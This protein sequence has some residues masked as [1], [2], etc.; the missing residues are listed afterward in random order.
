MNL[1]KLLLNHCIAF[2]L[3]G[4]CLISCSEP[5]AVDLIIENHLTS[6]GFNGDLSSKAYCLDGN[7]EIARYGINVPFSISTDGKSYYVF[8]QSELESDYIGD[9]LPSFSKL[10][11]D[12]KAFLVTNFSL[13]PEQLSNLDLEDDLKDDKIV[14]WEQFPKSVYDNWKSTEITIAN[15]VVLLKQMGY[16]FRL[17]GKAQFNGKKV[18]VLS[19]YGPNTSNDFKLFINTDD[20]LL[21]GMVFNSFHPEMGMVELTRTINSYANHGRYQYI[22]DWTDRKGEAEVH[23]SIQNFEMV[24]EP[25]HIAQISKATKIF[26]LPKEGIKSVIDNYLNALKMYCPDSAAVA[27]IEHGLQLKLL[28]GEFNE[29][30]SPGILANKLN[31]ELLNLTGDE[32]HRIFYHPLEY[33]LLKEQKE[34]SHP[35]DTQFKTKEIGNHLYVKLNKIP[36]LPAVKK[37]LDSV[38][39]ASVHKKSVILDLKYNRGGDPD[40]NMY[41]LSYFLEPHTV[42]YHQKT[43]DS[44]FTIKSQNTA[45]RLK[46]DE[47]FF[48][49][50]NDETSAEAEQLAYMLQSFAKGKV[51]GKTTFGVTH[52]PKRII[53]GDGIMAE[54]PYLDEKH[55]QTG[56][57]WNGLGVVPDIS[58]AA[59]SQEEIIGIIDSLN[60][61]Q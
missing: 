14:F 26:P 19:A 27:K 18:Y 52:T 37:S 25:T 40:F 24:N 13:N 17:N 46:P 3:L 23:F 31:R 4:V 16:T 8:E 47:Q 6:T 38:M 48:I 5:K 55:S 59:E 1:D 21:E 43:L 7:L 34:L 45:F 30:L 29:E 60:T 12:E 9:Y 53:I 56:E 32:Q 22:A 33:L 15:P 20:S 10:I 2:I 58:T 42:L 61:Y 41:L 39:R 54:I 35:S 36:H 28:N 49:L 11:F 51:I 57:N 50:V 44:T